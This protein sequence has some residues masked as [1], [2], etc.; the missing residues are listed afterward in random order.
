MPETLVHEKTASLLASLWVRNRPLLEERL[1]MLERAASA[2]S[3]GT[4]FEELREEAADTAHKLAGSLGM[5]GY[6]HGTRLA[7]QLELLLDYRTPDPIQVRT[8]T[9]QLRHTIFPTA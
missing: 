4:L 1:A 5:Y 3:A 9:T 2:A 6:D 8:L 7:R